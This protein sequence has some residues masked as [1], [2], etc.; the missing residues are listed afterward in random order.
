MV[1]H[2]VCFK[3]VDNSEKSKQEAKSVLLGM[4]GNVPSAKKVEV[5]TDFLMSQRSFDV[6]LQVTLEDRASLDVYQNDT[7]HC[8]VVKKYMHA[9]TVQ[10]VTVDYDF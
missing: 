5:G 8:E 6:I 1:K 3:L 10:S 2:V 9:H 4:I 7:Y